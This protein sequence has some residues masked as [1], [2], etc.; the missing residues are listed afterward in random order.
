MEQSAKPVIITILLIVAFIILSS[1]FKIIPPGHRGV[2]VTL[3]KVAEKE[4]PEG[5]VI[6]I[7]FIQTLAIIP[8]TQTTVTGNANSFSS[9]LQS[10]NIAFSCLYRIPPNKV[11]T[12]YQQYRG[13]FYDSFIE[14]RI[15][16]SVKQVSS[17]FRAEELVKHR[18]KVKNQVLEHLRAALSD[19]VE[20]ID[21]PLTNVDLSDQLEHAIEQKVVREQEA[22][23]KQFELEKAK[24]DAEITIVQA[25]AEAES[26][27]I[28]GEALKNS[29]QIVQL[30]LVK[31]WDGKSPTS[32]TVVGSDKTGAD[33]VLPIK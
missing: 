23:A 9:D 5:V 7:P 11:V 1:S 24:K 2:L 4:K 8:I 22:L 12:I 25:Q 32:V 3:G 30:E 17:Q 10:L 33:I 27:K 26:V 31:K 18:D 19:M 20:I 16:E 28:K 15:Q 13:N 6:K 21:I 14:P 29:P